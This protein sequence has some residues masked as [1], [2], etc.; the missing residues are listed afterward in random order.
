MWKSFVC[1]SSS[2]LIFI[3]CHVTGLIFTNNIPIKL[4]MWQSAASL[5]APPI[6]GHLHSICARTSSIRTPPRPYARCSRA[7]EVR[8]ERIWPR[9]A[10]LRVWEGRMRAQAARTWAP[11]AQ[12]LWMSSST[13]G[14]VPGCSGHWALG[15]SGCCG[16]GDLGRPGDGR[17][18]R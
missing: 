5:T 9:A 8:A 11:G 14:T 13:P 4:S 16:Y 15:R 18:C 7:R 12:T 6:R 2:T 17:V 3:L 10:R 1:I